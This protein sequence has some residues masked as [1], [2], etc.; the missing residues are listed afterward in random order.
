MQVVERALSYFE[1]AALLQ[2]NEP[3]WSM[4]VAGCHRRGGNMHKALTMYQRV[5]ALH[6]DNAECLRFLV[7]LCT[8]LGMREAQDYVLELKRLEKAREVRDRLG[9]GRPASSR[10]TNS[11]LSSRT[12]SSGFTPVREEVAAISPGHSAGAAR[13]RDSRA[14]HTVS[15]PDSGYG[16]SAMGNIFD[17][18]K[19]IIKFLNT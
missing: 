19:T 2:P 10:R 16:H 5:H 12:G 1:R 17:V 4:M 3:K 15:G 7:R 13:Q 8:E 11:G 14:V 6:P 9:S 18:F